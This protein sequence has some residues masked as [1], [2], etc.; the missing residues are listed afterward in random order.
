MYNDEKMFLLALAA[1]LCQVK[2][3]HL[4]KRYFAN[5]QLTIGLKSLHNVSMLLS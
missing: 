2:S 4:L 5:K 1:I 3:I